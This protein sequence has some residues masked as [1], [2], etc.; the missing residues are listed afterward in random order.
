MS[1]RDFCLEPLGVPELNGAKLVDAA[2]QAGFR[3][4]SIFAHAP[5]PE[6][7][8]DEVVG[9][10]GKRQEMLARMK[11]T[12]VGL[13]NL[14]CFNLTPEAD[15]ESFRRA[16][17]CGAALGARTATAIVWENADRADALTKYQRTCDMAAEHGIRVNVEFFAACRSLYGIA[18]VRDFVRDAGRTNGGIVLDILHLMRTSGGLLGL[19][20]IDPDMV[21]SIQICDGLAKPP[22]DALDEA[23]NRMLPGTGEFPIRAMLDWAPADLVIG[24]EAPQAALFGKVPPEERA[25]SM[26]EAA[27][28]AACEPGS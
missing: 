12:G 2:A 20:G 7:Q 24:V 25:L 28:R 11:E 10:L 27:A 8:V 1:G 26:Y 4:V 16:L 14:E 13:L 5:T 23:L 15:T 18:A 9:D 19:D 21:G 6:M 22:V 17:E 3:F